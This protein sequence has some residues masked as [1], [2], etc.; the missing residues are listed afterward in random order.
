M[1]T[2]LHAPDAR[3]ISGPSGFAVGFVVAGYRPNA[4]S[5]STL[6]A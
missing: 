2:T 5:A 1:T 3:P 4:Q 6:A